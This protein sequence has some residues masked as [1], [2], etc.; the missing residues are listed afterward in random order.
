MYSRVFLYCTVH[1]NILQ[2]YT[3]ILLLLTR[4]ALLR[5]LSY[6]IRVVN[7]TAQ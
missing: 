7:C 3:E 6:R 2:E 1:V 5:Q 4:V